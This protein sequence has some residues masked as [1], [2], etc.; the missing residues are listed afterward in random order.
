ML[1]K[2]TK[3]EINPKLS[4]VLTDRTHGGGSCCSLSSDVVHNAKKPSRDMNEWAEKNDRRTQMFARHPSNLEFLSFPD[5]DP[6][7]HR[8]YLLEM[9]CNENENENVPERFTCN[10]GPANREEHQFESASIFLLSF[11]NDEL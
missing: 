1:Q 2:E 7:H 8:R 9:V 3:D 6:K 4:V 5:R 10:H 11:G